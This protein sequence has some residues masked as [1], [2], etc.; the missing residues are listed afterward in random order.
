M[1]AEKDEIEAAKQLYLRQGLGV[2]DDAVAISALSGE[3]VDNLREAISAKLDSGGAVHHF[4][5]AASDGNRLAWLHSRG[6]V[7]DQ[8][9]EG[10]TLFIAV[11]LSP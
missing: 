11:R 7:L 9:M 2:R 6:E 3:G 4:Q 8:R 10:E 5:L 1:E